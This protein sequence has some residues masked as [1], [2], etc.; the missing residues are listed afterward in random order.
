[1]QN[2]LLKD[3]LENYFHHHGFVT[4]EEKSLEYVYKHAWPPLQ[5]TGLNIINNEF[6]ISCLLQDAIIKCWQHRTDMENIR[7]IYFFIRQDLVWKCFAWL[8]SRQYIFYHR[9]CTG[10]DNI[11]PPEEYQAVLNQTGTTDMYRNQDELTRLVYNAM[12][13][14][15]QTKQNM[16]TLAFKYGFNSKQIAKRCGVSTMAVAL[17]L[18]ESI[19]YLRK[20]IHKNPAVQQKPKDE[21]IDFNLNKLDAI[22][23]KIVVMRRMENKSFD[24]IAASIGLDSTEVKHHYMEALKIIR[25]K[26]DIPVK[27]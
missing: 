7:H 4:G 1:M 27:M 5:Q 26:N 24:G 22:K 12:P 17:Q 9:R 19:Q 20:I 10:L 3:C 21:V 8:R 16:M 18:K 11:S 25:N 14:L 15:P 2:I 6:V 13:F 23:A